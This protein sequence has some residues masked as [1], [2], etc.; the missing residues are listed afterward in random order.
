MNTTT[1]EKYSALR[2]LVLSASEAADDTAYT[3]RVSMLADCL[4]LRGVHCD[5][6][7]LED[8]PPLGVSNLASLSLLLRLPTLRHYD[9]IYAGAEEAG[10]TL[11]F[12]RHFVRAPIIYDAHSDVV[13]QAAHARA[14]RSRGRHTQAPLRVRIVAALAMASANHIITVSTPYQNAL[15][16]QCRPDQG[17]SLIRNGVDLELFKAHP[18]P[19]KP[20]YDFAY[21]GAFQ[22][23]QGSDMLLDAFAQLLDSR[24][25]FLII[26][27]RPE[28]REIKELFARRLGDQATLQDYTDRASMVNLLQDAAVLVNPLPLH[29]FTPYCFPTKFAEY[30]ALARPVLVTEGVESAD[31]V[32]RYEC[33]FVAA[34][35]AEALA[36][37]MRQTLQTAPATLQAMGARARTMAEKEFSWARI[38]DEYAT[39]V[40]RLCANKAT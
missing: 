10:Q 2:G 26:G 21:A 30:A 9:F 38:G 6:L 19:E 3:H 20:R 12:C 32:R 39:L 1:D 25:R 18:W 28:Q 35:N 31:F 4:Q 5:T 36:S 22:S 15:K 24:A 13:L 27:F 16:K 17:V 23:W 8:S 7:H 40:R 29:A 14:V 34:P 37:A 33:G 11:Y